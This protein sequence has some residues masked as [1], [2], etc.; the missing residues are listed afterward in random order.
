MRVAKT[1]ALISYCTAVVRLCFRLC[2]LLFFLC[3]S[4]NDIKHIQLA[5]LVCGIVPRCGII[6][7]GFHNQTV[8]I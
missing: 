3:D 7:L 4:S 5:F 1:K 8:F 6:S 2:I